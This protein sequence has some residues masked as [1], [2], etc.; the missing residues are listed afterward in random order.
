MRVIFAAFALSFASA[1]Q[2]QVTLIA[3]FVGT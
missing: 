1:A 3:P 2:A